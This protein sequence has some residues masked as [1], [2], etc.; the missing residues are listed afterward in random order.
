VLPLEVVAAA[1]VG[2]AVPPAGPAA[3]AEARAVLPVVA[4]AEL[5][6]AALPVVVEEAAVVVL[7]PRAEPTL[8]RA[9]KA[10]G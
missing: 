5:D 2:A 9:L 6:A 1:E 8:L 3:E 4:A 10:S 7:P